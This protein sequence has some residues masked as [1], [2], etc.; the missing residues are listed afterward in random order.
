MKRV[1]A[2][3][4][5]AGASGLWCA[6]TAAARGLSVCVVDHARTPGKKVRIAGG[7]KCNFTNLHVTH[8]DY[9]GRNPHFC[10]SALAR[11]SPWHMVEF[12]ATH[13][14]DW[15]ER[16]H[17]QLFCL[18]GD[19]I[20]ADALEEDCRTRGAELLLRHAITSVTCADG[21]YTITTDQGLIQAPSLVVALG[22]PAWPQ[23][24]A[25]DLGHRIAKQ[26][27]HAVIAPY[28]ALVPLAMAQTWPLQGLSGIA[29]P[30]T[31]TCNDRRFTENL[32][33]THTGISGPVVLHASCHWQKGAAIHINFLPSMQL[34]E[35]LHDAGGKPLVRTVLGKLLPDRLATA[36]VS[37]PLADKQVAQ[38][39]RQDTEHLCHRVHDFTITPTRTEGMRRAEVTGGGVDTAHVSSKTMESTRQAGLYLVGEVLDVTGQLGGFNLH[40]AWASGQAAG[41]ALPSSN[42]A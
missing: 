12:L 6:R 8:A 31:I 41:M 30:A 4:L 36:L 23:A 16:D 22:G 21:L 32:L 10:K 35:A 20:L 13:G 15:E 40:W 19:G 42:P 33:F 38:L 37:G 24:G 34:E 17:G 28:P 25:T 2:V 27:G 3:I 5:G 26:F 18:R 9:V 7:G 39:S 29:V 1:D 14:I 11:F